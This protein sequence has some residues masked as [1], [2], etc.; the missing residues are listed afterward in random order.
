MGTLNGT[1]R[2]GGFNVDAL[3]RLTFVTDVSVHG[4]LTATADY[5]GVSAAITLDQM[6]DLAF[7]QFAGSASPAAGGLY[8]GGPLLAFQTGPQ[9]AFKLSTGINFLGSA[10]LAADVAVS[11]GSDGGTVMA[12]HLTA[13][14]PL[15]P[16]GILGCDFSYATHPAGDG[17]FTIGNWPEFTLAGVLVDIVK[18]VKALAD[19]SAGSPCG[20]LSDFI[21]N[22]AFTGS[23]TVKPSVSL[24]HDVSGFNL[25]FALTG[26]YSLTITGASRPFVSRSLPAFTVLIPVTTTWGDLPG[27]LA[28]GVAK[29]ATVFAHDLLSDRTTIAMFL[30]MVVGQAATAVGLEL[31]CNGLV[32]SSVPGSSGSAADAIHS[33]G[34]PAAVGAVAAAAGAIS[35]WLTGSGS[36]PAGPAP[37]SGSTVGTPYLRRLV[38]AAGS[39][40]GTWDAAGGASGYTFELLRPDGTVLAQQDFGLTIT[41]SLSVDPGS[42]PTGA[43]Q[44]Q[45]RGTRGPQVGA[46]SNQLSLTRTVGPAVTLSYAEPDLVASW[47]DAGAGSYVV[48][49]FDLSGA[50]LGADVTVGATVH[51]ASVPLPDPLPGAYAAAVESIMTDQFPSAFGN[52]ATLVVLSLGPPRTGAITRSASTPTWATP[53]SGGTLTILWTP[54]DLAAQGYE[55]RVTLGQVTLASLPTTSVPTIVALTQPVAAG[56][57][58][59]VQVRARN[60]V[61]L[62]PWASATFVAWD[63]PAPASAQLNDIAG[64]LT[65]SWAAVAVAGAPA[66]V[67][68]LRLVQLI[69]VKSVPA[70]GGAIGA[71]GPPVTLRRDDGAQPVPGTQYAAQVQAGIGGNLGPWTT[72]A[73]VVVATITPPAGVTLTASGTSLSLSWVA[74]PVPPNLTGPLSYDVILLEGTTQVGEADGVAGV[75]LS[76][77]RSDNQLLV[78]GQAYTAQVRATTAG[79]ASDWA[80]SP[81]VTVMDVPRLVGMSGGGGALA[82]QWTPSTVPG[83]EYDVGLTQEIIGG[84]Q[85]VIPVTGPTPNTQIDTSNM[86]SARYYVQVRARIANSTGAWSAGLPFSILAP[87]T[88]LTVSVGPT[89][90]TASWNPVPDGEVT[91]TVNLLNLDF[92]PADSWSVGTQLTYTFAS[93]GAVKPGAYLLTVAANYGSLGTSA[94]EP[95]RVYLPPPPVTG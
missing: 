60:A 16:F 2:S 78:P 82:V 41:G 26:T 12:G 89:S 17:T 46:W 21:A 31:A 84:T 15:T 59:L 71:S 30:A 13:A 33:A 77:A 66:A 39:V 10:F 54:G 1:S 90:V 76:P 85:S 44:G 23:F 62:S 53:P 72:S 35:G 68:N 51:Q 70:V 42:L 22:N 74:P 34:G 50:Q 69:T 7:I 20:T 61:A 8:T 29:A 38:Y 91:Y 94:S 65:A 92:T 27:A 24:K 18:A 83:A 4:L 36:G 86:P 93:A 19:T 6:V 64:A 95:V 80:T 45:V 81:A 79:H 37:G 57:S 25:A 75:T 52:R 73:L 5:S 32:D 87:P 67:Y 3:I 63:V 43:Y 56:A 47:P 58:L 14:Q 40:T 49:F 55:L 48:R 11:K 88:G 9:P 28:A